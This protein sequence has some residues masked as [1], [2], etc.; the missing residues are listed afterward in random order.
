MNEYEVLGNLH[1][2]IDKDV[3]NKISEWI[4][5]HNTNYCLLYPLAMIEMGA[6]NE[7][8]ETNDNLFRRCVTAFVYSKAIAIKKDMYMKK[9]NI[10][11]LKKYMMEYE[12]TLVPLYQ[13]FRFSR[14]INDINP[15]MYGFLDPVMMEVLLSSYISIILQGMVMLQLNSLRIILMIPT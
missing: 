15:I 8:P 14:E 13:N 4:D 9:F 11:G 5:T 3:D 10:P 12:K 7:P 2:I 6:M 1:E